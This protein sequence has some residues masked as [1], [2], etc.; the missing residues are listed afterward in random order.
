MKQ[1]IPS[2]TKST[3]VSENPV[4]GLNPLGDQV[5]VKLAADT[6]RRAVKLLQDAIQP[7]D[8]SA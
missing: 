1:T 8:E 6:I 2:R 3:V 4:T 7:V 5:T